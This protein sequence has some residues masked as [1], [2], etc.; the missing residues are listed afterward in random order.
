MTMK[1]HAGYEIS[2]DCLQPTPMILTLSVHPSRRPALL[3][4][5]RML[6]DPL[7]PTKKYCDGFGNI[8]HVIPAPAGRLTISADFHV[9]DSG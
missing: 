4:S 8:C 7:V 9:Q 6:L 1:I 3:T 2:Y 5:D